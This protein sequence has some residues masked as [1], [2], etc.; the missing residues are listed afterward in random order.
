MSK[1][2]IKET[3]STYPTNWK[4]ID[5]P[6]YNLVK[7]LL[8]GKGATE[9]VDQEKLVPDQDFWGVEPPEEIII[10][11]GSTRKAYMLSVV[12][13]GLEVP[14]NHPMDFQDFMV[15]A[16]F[17][18][19]GSLKA[20]T[21][22][23]EFHGVPVYAESAAAGETVG[24]NPKAEAVNKAFWLS[25]QPQYVGRHVLI[26][27]TDTVDFVDRDGNGFVS[28]GE[29]GLG[30]PMN[31]AHYPKKNSL[32]KSKNGLIKT[33]GDKIFAWQENNFFAEYT[34]ENFALGLD[35]VHTNA[36][37]IIDLLSSGEE[38]LVRIWEVILKSEIDAEFFEKY[39]PVIDQGGG[40][41][42]QQNQ[43]WSSTENIFS[44]LDQE[45]QGILAIIKDTDPQFF[46]FLIIFQISG[47]PV[48]NILQTIENWAKKNKEQLAKK[49]VVVFKAQ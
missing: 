43:H 47:M 5:H 10:A 18:G 41:A 40:G 21:F 30:K 31:Q 46:K 25:E 33:I 14:L 11:T 15:H 20:K 23:G 19:D 36:I 49:E 7:D 2:N 12:L 37:A 1:T 29:E 38:D 17:N 42:S 34:K 39:R 28:P 26:I 13:N 9:L 6:F 22:L 16:I 8:A 45:T 44:S 4:E 27:S 32:M 48:M 35:I 3:K 24:N